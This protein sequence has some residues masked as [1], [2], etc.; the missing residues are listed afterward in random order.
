MAEKK[1]IIFALT[2]AIM[3]VLVC[4]II[5]LFFTFIGTLISNNEPL[6]LISFVYKYAAQVGTVILGVYRCLLFIS[7]NE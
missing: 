4:G 1:N 6:M 2:E 7:K 5:E 3:I